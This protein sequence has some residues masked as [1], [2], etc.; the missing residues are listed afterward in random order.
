MRIK[1]SKQSE[2]TFNASED[3]KPP[4][5]AYQ[6]KP[7]SAGKYEITVIHPNGKALDGKLSYENLY[8]EVHEAANFDEALNIARKIMESQFFDIVTAYEE[9]K[10][11]P[12]YKKGFVKL[13]TKEAAV[14]EAKKTAES[15]KKQKK[16][17]KEVKKQIK[18]II[19]K[20]KKSAKSSKINNKINK[21]Q[22]KAKK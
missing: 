8:Q 12:N 9:I 6:V 20:E 11:I 10:H 3:K 5:L 21:K 4:K 17:A 15:E 7:V 22:K 2:N 19:S 16:E 18:K 14:E 13:K 1:V